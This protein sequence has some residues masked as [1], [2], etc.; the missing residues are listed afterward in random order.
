MKPERTSVVAQVVV[1]SRRAAARIVTSASTSCAEAAVSTCLWWVYLIECRNGAIYTG[2]TREVAARYKQHVAGK[3]AKYTRMNPPV[4]LIW[5][6]QF[7]SRRAAAQAEVA[8]KRLPAKQKLQAAI[9][10]EAGLM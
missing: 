2:I 8:I 10:F 5:S 9:A 3:G 6:R 4:R 7:Q 1:P